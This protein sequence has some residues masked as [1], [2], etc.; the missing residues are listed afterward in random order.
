MGAGR[1]QGRLSFMT[2]H[3]RTQVLCEGTGPQLGTQQRSL[4]RS[5]GRVC[6][7]WDKKLHAV[8]RR[9]SCSRVYPTSACVGSTLP[10]TH[11]L[12]GCR[13]RLRMVQMRPQRMVTSSRR[14]AQVLLQKCLH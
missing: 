13:C 1:H 3:K 14:T 4:P 9:S 6:P 11:R 8:G 7:P 12:S 10:N 5:S 2:T